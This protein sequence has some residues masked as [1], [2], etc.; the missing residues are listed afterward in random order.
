MQKM[1]I[2][3]PK[4]ERKV[5]SLFLASSWKA[6]FI[7]LEIIANIRRM[8]KGTGFCRA[9]KSGY[10]SGATFSKAHVAEA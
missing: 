4:R 10:D 1:P 3:T 2:V 6:I 5:R 9:R 7:L 8:R